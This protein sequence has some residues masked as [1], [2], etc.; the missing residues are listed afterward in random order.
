MAC[1]WCHSQLF[2]SDDPEKLNDENPNFGMYCPK[3]EKDACGVG[4]A[5][6]INGE[7]HR[8]I[9]DSA[10]TILERMEHRGGVGCDNETGDGAGILVSI[11]HHFYKYLLML[12]WK[13]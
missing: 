12:V 4:F 5:V 10:R 8:H 13:N 7:P 6:D 2:P 3:E 1:K 9:V 11:P